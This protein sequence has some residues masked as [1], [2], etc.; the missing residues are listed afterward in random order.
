MSVCAATAGSARACGGGG[1]GDEPRGPLRLVD[2]HVRDHAHTSQA[3]RAPGRGGGGGAGVGE[4]GRGAEDGRVRRGEER[5]LVRISVEWSED[6]D[7]R[8]GVG[9][10]K[11]R[12]NRGTGEVELTV[13]THQADGHT[14]VGLKGREVRVRVEMGGGYEGRWMQGCGTAIFGYETRI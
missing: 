9:G 4:V 8:G 14:L 13:T 11:V 7:I 3:E 1:G 2:G 12:G 10:E 6:E 5:E